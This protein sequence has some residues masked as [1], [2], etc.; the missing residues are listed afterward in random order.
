LGI[1]L[2]SKRGVRRSNHDRSQDRRDGWVELN[3]ARDDYKASFGLVWR[4]INR[5]KMTRSSECRQNHAQTVLDSADIVRERISR[6]LSGPTCPGPPAKASFDY[7]TNWELTT[8]PRACSPVIKIRRQ[9][10]TNSLHWITGPTISCDKAVMN[11]V[12]GRIQSGEVIPAQHLL[13]HCSRSRA[14][15]ETGLSRSRQATV[16]KYGR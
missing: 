4:V 6:H 3:G 15:R 16:I 2:S 14:R 11:L 10:L 12:L 7:A 9:R 5:I 8:W 1:P 13:T